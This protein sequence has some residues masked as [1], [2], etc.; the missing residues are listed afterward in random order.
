L[1]KP[2]LSEL[3]TIAGRKLRTLGE[4]VDAACETVAAGVGSVLLSVGRHGAVWVDSGGTVV[5]A[6]AVVPDAVNNVGAGDALLAGFLAR[7][8]GAPALSEAVAWSIAALRSPGTRMLPLTDADRRAV[9]VH[10]RVDR[11]RVLSA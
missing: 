3:E 6:E 7:G 5:H 8:A 9:V 1:I 11:D 2:N 4:A 10:D